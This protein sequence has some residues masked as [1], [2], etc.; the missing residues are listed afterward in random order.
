MTI[1]QTV[2]PTSRKPLRLWP[3]VALTLLGWVVMFA[4]PVVAPQYGGFAIL[5]G[6]VGGLLVLVWW[7]FFSRAPWSERLGA[8][9]LMVAAVFATKYSVHESVAGAGMG[10]LLYICAIPVMGLALVVWAVATRRLAG[11][12]R[13]AWL[14]ATILLACVGLM[15]VR[16]DGLSNTEGVD[17]E[18][19]WSPTAEE[20]LLAQ[21]GE[22]PVPVAPVAANDEPAAVAP[23]PAGSDTAQPAAQAAGEQTAEVEIESAALSASST[24]LAD[25]EATREADWPGFRGPH[26]DGVVHGSRIGTDWSQSP[27]VELWRRPVGPAWSSFAVDGD[28]FYTQEQLGDEEIV[29]CYELRTGE[30]VW[31]HRDAARFWEA[32]AGAGPRGTPTLADGRVYTFGGTGILNALDARDGSVLWSR[33]AAAD[34]GRETPY[35]GFASSPVVAGDVVIVAAAGTL[36]AYDLATGERRWTGPEGKCCYSSPHL[37]T[38]DGVPQILFLNGAGAI[39]VDLGSGDVLWKHEWPG[40]GIVQPAV[41]EEGDVLIGSGSGMGGGSGL[42]RVAVTRGIEE[43]SAERGAGAWTVEERWT[44]AGLKPYFNDFVQH[45]GHAYGFDG[46]ILASID[47]ADGERKWKGGR[48]GDG[49]LVLLADQDLLLV[50]SEKGELALVDASPDQF[51]ERAR[52][53]AIEGKTWN[54]P[55]VVGDVVLVRNSQEMAAFRVSPAGG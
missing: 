19:R 8:L 18:W 9:V 53:K 41:T 38:I 28:R 13:R 45:Q 12:P 48:Y 34:T 49:Q 44:S 3:G 31:Q 46:A 33:N 50:L 21:V 1:A 51:T 15:V 7:L 6:A 43:W 32:N 2:E 29:S 23:A 20:R 4:L 16:V 35:W 39:S 14:V 54:H 30:P 24:A 10:M 17:F 11:G 42:R 5:G 25:R 55:V 36:A 52:F 22:E 27:P 40:D 26:R 37:A 47:L